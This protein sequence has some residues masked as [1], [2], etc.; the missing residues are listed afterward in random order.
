MLFEFEISEFI[1][2]FFSFALSFV[3]KG[4]FVVVKVMADCIQPKFNED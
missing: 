4:A 2:I 1:F 3:L